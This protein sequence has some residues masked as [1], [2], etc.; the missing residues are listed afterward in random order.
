MYM[1]IERLRAYPIVHGDIIDRGPR[2]RRKESLCETVIAHTLATSTI[3]SSVYMYR[4]TF[5]TISTCHSATDSP[6][7]V[8]CSG[9]SRRYL[10]PGSQRLCKTCR[11]AERY[12]FIDY[13]TYKCSEKEMA[14]SFLIGNRYQLAMLLHTHTKKHREMPLIWARSV[15]LGWVRSLVIALSSHVRKLALE[16]RRKVLPM[17]WLHRLMPNRS[18][19]KFIESDT[20][21]LVELEQV[22]ENKWYGRTSVDARAIVQITITSTVHETRHHYEF[23]GQRLR[24]ERSICRGRYPALD[25]PLP[26]AI[27]FFF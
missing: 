25:H 18:N 3:Y 15:Y 4:S 23:F 14:F 21:G 6:G 2:E 20:Q 10:S 26:C 17:R 19:S 1:C 22:N 8:N 24:A 11:A 5:E 7:S 12:I 16:M 13:K 9:L 27:S